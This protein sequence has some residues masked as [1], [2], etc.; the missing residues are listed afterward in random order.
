MPRWRMSNRVGKADWKPAGFS[1]KEKRI[2]AHKAIQFQT[3]VLAAVSVNAAAAFAKAGSQPADGLLASAIRS[4]SEPLPWWAADVLAFAGAHPLAVGLLA[5]HGAGL[6]V[7]RRW[8]TSLCR[9]AASMAW[10]S[11]HAEASPVSWTSSNR[12]H[13]QLR[14]A[15]WALNGLAAVGL[16]A[17]VWVSKA[18]LGL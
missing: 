15:R 18:L 1:S 16:G 8:V 11:V 14:M 5:L 4:F 12:V 6:W 2:W 13:G 10:I 17:A 7:V 9:E 3:L